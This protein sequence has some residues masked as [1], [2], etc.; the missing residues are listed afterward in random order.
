VSLHADK[1]CANLFFSVRV[2]RS[3]NRRTDIAVVSDVVCKITIKVNIFQSNT[4]VYYS[5]LSATY[6]GL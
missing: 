2:T 3:D 6:F 1:K 5:K 4:T